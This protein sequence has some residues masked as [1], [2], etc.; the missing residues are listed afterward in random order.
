METKTTRLDYQIIGKVV[1]D[2]SRVLDLGCG[3]GDLMFFLAKKKNAKVQ[4]IELNE[5]SIYKCVEKGLS[6]FH[7]D[8]DSGLRDYPDKSF[9]A[10][11]LNQS[12]QEVKGTEFVLNEALRVGRKVIV[13]FPNFAHFSARL[14][15]FFLGRAPVIESLPFHWY[16]T[17]NKHFLSIKDF[18]NYCKEKNIKILEARYLGKEKFVNHFPNLFAYNAVFVIKR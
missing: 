5:N 16:D 2:G 1:E 13:V 9:D 8:V 15:L 11:I 7:G 4:G 3:D 6:V 14:K 17:P 10:V 18:Q 12:L